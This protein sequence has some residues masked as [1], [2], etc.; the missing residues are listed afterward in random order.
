MNTLS[1][2]NQKQGLNSVDVELPGSA[3]G[4][5]S[6]AVSAL[7]RS[8]K[9]VSASTMTQGTVT[10]VNFHDSATYLNVGGQEIGFSDIVSVKQ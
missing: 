5:Y 6:F 1:F 3:K 2:K 10:G 8:G 9:S 7:D 4:T